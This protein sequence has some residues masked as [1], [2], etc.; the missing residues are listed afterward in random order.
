MKDGES[1]V[2]GR[3]MRGG[4]A[5]RSGLLHEGDEILEVNGVEVYG[6]SVNDVCDLV[7]SMTGTITFLIVPFGAGQP[8][9]TKWPAG[10]VWPSVIHLKAHFDYNPED[11][12]YIPCKELGISFIKV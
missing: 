7:G 3:I 5:D 10:Q 12:L 1:I 2:V 11:D 6:K 8:S 4:V 9:I